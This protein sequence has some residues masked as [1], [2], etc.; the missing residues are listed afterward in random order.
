MSTLNKCNQCSSASCPLCESKE[1]SRKKKYSY[2]QLFLQTHRVMFLAEALLE[3]SVEFTHAEKISTRNLIDTLPAMM[4]ELHCCYLRLTALRFC[5]E[6][7]DLPDELAPVFDN[8]RSIRN[9]LV[10][11]LN[12]LDE[13]FHRTCGCPAKDPDGAFSEKDAEVNVDDEP[14]TDDVLADED[15][16]GDLAPDLACEITFKFA[17]DI[18]EDIADVI[19]EQTSEFVSDLLNEYQTLAESGADEN[20]CEGESEDEDSENVEESDDGAEENE[21]EEDDSVDISELLSGIER[22][23]GELAPEVLWLLL[24]KTARELRRQGEMSDE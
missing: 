3:Q 15:D 22:L 21:A 20:G 16:E 18:N 17:D 11:R 19:C 6:N 1:P 4:A 12:K 9:L 23:L 7:S 13:Y 24:S 2:K 14:D 10:A 8:L 5:L